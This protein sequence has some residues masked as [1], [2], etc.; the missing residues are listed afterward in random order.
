[1]KSQQLDISLEVFGDNIHV[2]LS[3]NFFAEQIPNVRQKFEG[4]VQEGYHEYIVLLEDVELRSS[5][6]M[7]FFSRN[8]KYYSGTLC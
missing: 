8:T 6:V 5:D 3:G 2:T 7:H 1:M 4:F